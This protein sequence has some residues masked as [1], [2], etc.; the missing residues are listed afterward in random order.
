MVGIEPCARV[1][2]MLHRQF[3]IDAVFAVYLIIFFLIFLM[4]GLPM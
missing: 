1:F 4:L 3:N 2:A